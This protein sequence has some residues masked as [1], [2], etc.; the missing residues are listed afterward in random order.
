M[1]ELLEAR[2]ATVEESLKAERKDREARR[3]GER[4]GREGK[5]AFLA[6]GKEGRREGEARES[7]D[8]VQHSFSTWKINCSWGLGE[9]KVG[10]H[11]VPVQLSEPGFA[12]PS[13]SEED[14]EEVCSVVCASETQDCRIP[15]CTK[16]HG[17]KKETQIKREH[18]TVESGFLGLC[19]RFK[20]FVA[21][22]L[23]GLRL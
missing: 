16:P 4:E 5:R 7:I 12:D 9:E 10:S 2:M 14:E 3:E 21:S 17:R 19:L 15:E 11:D 13:I 6:S 8:S 22:G 23:W 1:R 20:G 18:H